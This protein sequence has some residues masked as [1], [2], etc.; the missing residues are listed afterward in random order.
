MIQSLQFHIQCILSMHQQQGDIF[1]YPQKSD[2]HV[3]ITIFSLVK[4]IQL[5]NL[6][7]G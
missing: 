1:D 7:L 6:H 5:D 4:A 3:F 2:L